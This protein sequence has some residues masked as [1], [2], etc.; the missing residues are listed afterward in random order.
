MSGAPRLEID[1]DDV[2]HN[3]RALVGRLAPRGISVQGVTK[4]V[5]GNP[6]VGAAMMRGGARG[7][8]DSRIEN[9]AVLRRGDPRA[10]RT[11]VR[12]PMLSQV[13]RVVVEAGTSLNTEPVVL[14]ALSASAAGHRDRHAVVLMVEL[15]DL[16]EGVAVGD[17]VDL[18]RHVGA[19][20]GLALVGLGTNLACQS[21]V[22]PDQRSMDELSGLVDAV[23]R[24]SSLVLPVVSGGNSAN[25]GW[26]M[27]TRSVGRINQLRLG[28][29]ILL[30]TD[31]LR[32][33][34]IPGLRLDACVLVGEVIEVKTKPA[35][36][37]GA[38]AQ[39]A[40][41]RRPRRRGRGTVR[42]AL[43]AVGRQDTDPDGLTVPDGMTILGMSSDH[44]VL[45]V[46]DH[47]TA[48]GDELRFGV[49]YSALLRASTSPYVTTVEHRR[50]DA[51][52]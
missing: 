51:L 20:G 6:S 12:S 15:G 36:A 10:P 52:R 8:A 38:T 31:P 19:L 34:S 42:Q 3:T 1:L 45:D 28:E 23:E 48:V 25:L 5:C 18:A 40:F 29:S 44:L 50:P 47:A 35:R 21:G 7:L 22:V 13:D 11:L 41:E 16:R 46:G 27:T 33:A 32:R 39:S 30:G 17:V 49:D 2:E 26:A 43:V 14:A 37:W 24:S 4:A 9:L